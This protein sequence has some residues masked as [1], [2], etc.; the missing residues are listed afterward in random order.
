[1][2]RAPFAVVLAVLLAVPVVAAETKFSLTGENTKI[3]FV[4]TKPGGR[5]EG[6]FKKLSGTATLDG[7]DAA[8]LKV[9]VEVD[10]ESLYADDA[11]LTAHLKS[12]DFFGVK[13][14]P[15]ATFKTTKVEK[16]AKGYNITGDLTMLGRT[17]AVSVPATVTAAGDTLTLTSEFKINRNDWGMTYG[18]GKVDDIVS[19][20]VVVNAKK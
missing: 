3:T 5:H 8:G 2:Y 18:K 17:K 9:E 1:M 6:G 10:T 16:T 12:P 11:K 4:G 14:H 15:K 13:D 7:T 20:K 19:L